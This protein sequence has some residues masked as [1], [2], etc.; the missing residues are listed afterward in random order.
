VSYRGRIT[1]W[2][3]CSP[4]STAAVV[5]RLGGP[6]S[7]PTTWLSSG[8]QAFARSPPVRRPVPR[9][10]VGRLDQIGRS[11]L[12][13]SV[14]TWCLTWAQG[15]APT[16]GDS[17]RHGPMTHRLTHLASRSQ[18]RARPRHF[19][20]HSLGGLL[21]NKPSALIA[22]SSTSAASAGAWSMPVS[23][24]ALTSACAAW[25]AARACA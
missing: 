18:G 12:L 5:A 8:S 22:V 10:R 17:Q 15:L 4:L 6:P 25:I 14:A 9:P 16:V 23:G 13:P 1:C 2:R 3:G 21:T 7:R 19:V 24:V 20:G 11:D